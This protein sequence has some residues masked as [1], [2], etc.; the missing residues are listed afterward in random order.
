MEAAVEAARAGR[1]TRRRAAARS[2][3]RGDGTCLL[4]DGQQAMLATICQGLAGCASRIGY[5][6]HSEG[7]IHGPWNRWTA[8][9][10]SR[11][12]TAPDRCREPAAPKSTGAAQESRSCARCSSMLSGSSSSSM[13]NSL[14]GRPSAGR[15][16]SSFACYGAPP[17]YCAVLT[18]A[19]VLPGRLTSRLVRSRSSHLS[20]GRTLDHPR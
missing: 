17:R 8:T 1:A 7:G 3:A 12:K 4:G 2:G 6:Q 10:R 19:A 15:S 11:A 5:Q 13:I 20:A 16:S 9:A 18:P 14:R